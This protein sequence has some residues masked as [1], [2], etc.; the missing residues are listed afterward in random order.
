MQRAAEN[1]EEAGGRS[2]PAI[3]CH[4]DDVDIFRRAWVGS[5]VTGGSSQ[6]SRSACS[7][8]SLAPAADDRDVLQSTVTPE[9]VSRLRSPS[10][11][12]GAGEDAED[13]ARSLCGPRGMSSLVEMT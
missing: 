10:L 12:E 7:P 9:N 3:P 8:A 5:F 11:D 2:S 4:A 1:M 6:S 13:G